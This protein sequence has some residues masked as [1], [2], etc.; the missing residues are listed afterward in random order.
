MFYRVLPSFTE[1]F[2]QVGSSLLC[3]WNFSNVQQVLLITTSIY[4]VLPSFT[5]WMTFSSC[6]FSGNGFYL[7]LPSFNL[8]SIESFLVHS[9]ELSKFLW[10]QP[11]SGRWFSLL[12]SFTDFFFGG[13]FLVGGWRSS[14]VLVVVVS[15]FFNIHFKFLIEIDVVLGSPFRLAPE[16]RFLFCFLFFCF[17]FPWQPRRF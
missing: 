14:F 17:T 11:I 10:N 16:G 5:K 8:C 13:G 4:R 12:P 6:F 1:F 2:F 9:S 15:F 3:I 7:V